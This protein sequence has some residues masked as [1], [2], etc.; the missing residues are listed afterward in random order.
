MVDR[1]RLN[2]AEITRIIRLLQQEHEEITHLHAQTRHKVD[3]MRREWIGEAANKFINQMG[4]VLLPATGRLANAL[5]SAGSTLSSVM[6]TIQ[7]ADI[8]TSSYFKQ[9]GADDANP[10]MS[11]AA[12]GTQSSAQ[13]GLFE[14]GKGAVSTMNQY[15][16]A[17][18]GAFPNGE[19]QNVGFNFSGG[20][21][22]GAGPQGALDGA[23]GQAAA[24]GA[25][26]G[27]AGQVAGG[28]PP[29]G[30]GIFA[31]A[32][33][34]VAGG[35]APT[36]SG[37]FAGATGQVAGGSPPSGGGVAAGATGQA[38][39]GDNSSSGEPMGIGM[40]TGGD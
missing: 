2:Y 14:P 23:F 19:T 10:R 27:A 38:P 39:V 29:G 18:M 33:G 26:S 3:V 28:S 8:E 21:S 7:D 36:G 37:I 17:G 9:L 25:A 32:A 12:F 20:F 40:K 4:D 6:K 34:Q 22:N 30:S 5:D 11:Q 1:T 31:G 24:G 16:A 15:V 35:G 13:S